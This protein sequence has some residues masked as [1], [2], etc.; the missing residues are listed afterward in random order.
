MTAQSDSGESVLTLALPHHPHTHSLPIG[1][2][3]GHE[4]EGLFGK[5]SG[6]HEE[7]RQPEERSKSGKV[8]AEHFLKLF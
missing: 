7:S 2:V 5:E 8:D 3:L 1:Q 6:T 4:C